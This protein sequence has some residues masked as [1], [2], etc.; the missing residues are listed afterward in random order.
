MEPSVQAQIGGQRVSFDRLAPYYRPMEAVAAGRIMQRCRTSFL[1]ETIGR[2]RALLVGEGPGRFLIELLRATPRMEVT[3]L[4]Q[5]PQMIRQAKSRLRKKGL[6]A[7]RVEFQTVDALTWNPPVQ[8]FDLIATH[9][10][11]DCFGPE[12]LADLIGKLGQSA[13]EDARWLLGDFCIPKR[14]WR[15]FRARV[16]HAA[17]YAFFRVAT[18]LSAKRLTPPDRFMQRAGFQ[19]ME[20]RLFSLGLLHSDLWVRGGPTRLNPRGPENVHGAP[21][22]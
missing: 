17:M 3:V 7:S 6:D 15:R 16:I 4:E 11:L 18:G 19:R 10:F 2:R 8:G 5:S 22:G 13:T 14:G 20:R 1:A 21:A 9:F 12:E